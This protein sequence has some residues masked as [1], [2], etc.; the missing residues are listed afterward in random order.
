MKLRLVVGCTLCG[1]AACFSQTQ[2]S[3][4]RSRLELNRPRR[5]AGAT[6]VRRPA[7]G[8]PLVE[9]PPPAS[10]ARRSSSANANA[11]A[12]AVANVGGTDDASVENAVA[13]D[14]PGPL[15]ATAFLLG[16]AA[17]WGTYPSTIKCLFASPGS[18]IS[19][20]EITLLRFL[21]M[22][23]IS[24]TAY[25]VTGPAPGSDGGD[26]GVGA[27]GAGGAAPTFQEQLERR[28]PSSVYLAAGELGAI[29]LAGTLCNTYGLSLI[30]ALTGA[31]LL[32]SI[33]VFTPI[34]AAA[35]GATA[36]E[37]EV[38]VPT[39][40]GSVVAVG[41]TTYAL[42]PDDPGGA[43]ARDHHH[44][45]LPLTP[46]SRHPPPTNPATSPPTPHAATPPASVA[47]PSL[48]AGEA[49]IL[50]A[51]FFFAAAKVRLSS[52]L[53]LH[54]AESLTTGRVVGQAGLA[55]AG[56]GLLDETNAMHEILPS[57]NG[58]LGLSI[59]DVLN[60]ASGWFGD[61]SAQQVFW[62]VAS[63]ILSGAAALYCQGKGQSAVPA[64]TAQL[65]YSTMPVFGAFWA[66]VLLHEP[67]TFHEVTGGALLL[68]GLGAASLVRPIAP[69]EA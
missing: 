69:G 60:Q 44:P 24:V 57:Q 61:F 63:S 27:G 46:P 23:A 55:A 67:V 32:A 17:L 14:V 53:K 38:D 21:F 54:S 34:I 12:D 43:V 48:G 4:K 56:L 66:F 3:L 65:Y 36:A 5:G 1:T 25:T 45:S 6:I 42:L 13:S 30:P 2:T 68:L 31:L 50:G 64:P 19:P 62:I 52:H 33:N 35:A 16:A 22:A 11:D 7:G 26:G 58:G 39:W 8:P 49:G 40:L 10:S 41:A 29:G 28:V 9:A 15:Q 20:P 37:R 47:M 59:S 51:A 18:H